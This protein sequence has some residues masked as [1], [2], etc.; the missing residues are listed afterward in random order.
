ML[1]KLTKIKATA[2]ETI[3]TVF[4]QMKILFGY[5]EVNIFPLVLDIVPVGLGL[6]LGLGLGVNIFPRVLDIVPVLN[7][8]L[9]LNPEN[10]DK[11]VSLIYSISIVLVRDPEAW[12]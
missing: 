12:A 3:M 1:G 2:A 9:A 10:K 8:F 5:M 4:N 6:G 7:T 11:A